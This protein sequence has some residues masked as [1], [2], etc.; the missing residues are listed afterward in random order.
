MFITSQNVK[1]FDKLSHDKLS[2]APTKVISLVAK[3]TPV[4]TVM[5]K[6]K[7]VSSVVNS[8]I[9]KATCKTNSKSKSNCNIDIYHVKVERDKM[10]AKN[11]R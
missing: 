4:K 9:G 10:A 7:S 3:V 5:N 11:A 2:Q 6:S 1:A 8:V